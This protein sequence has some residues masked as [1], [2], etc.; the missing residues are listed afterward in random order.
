MSTHAQ[1]RSITEIQIPTP[2]GH[3]ATKCWNLP[4]ADPADLKSSRVPPVICLHGWQDNAG[5]WDKLIPLLDKEIPFICLDFF[6]HGK[7]SP[8][9]VGT[10]GDN[11]MYVWDVKRLVD[12]FGLES[13]VNFMAHSLG[14]AVSVCFAATFPEMM[15][16]LLTFDAPGM[17]PRNSADA[18]QYLANAI[19]KNLEYEASPRPAPRYTYDQALERFLKGRSGQMTEESAR[20]LL[21]RGLKLVDEN[22]EGEPLYEYARDIRVTFPSFSYFTAEQVMAFLKNISCHLQVF[23]FKQNHWARVEA[24]NAEWHERMTQARAVAYEMYKKNC[25]SFQLVE[26]DGKH[27]GH[28][29]HPETVAAEVNT[30]LK[31]GES[32]L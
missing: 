14:G 29:D 8:R 30:F 18:P 21:R 16:K 3:L 5:T 20:I 32:K 15:N 24:G 11:T 19:K 25:R 9:P 4:S 10:S 22:E 26:V 27:H 12:F 7:S 2:W 31:K 23:L 6:G 28:L 13:G 17:F 1:E